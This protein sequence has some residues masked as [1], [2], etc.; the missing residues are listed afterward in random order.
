MIKVFMNFSEKK[1]KKK[2]KHESGT[3]YILTVTSFEARIT[4]GEVHDI[5]ARLW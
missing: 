4:R 1:K 5:G 3:H 2:K